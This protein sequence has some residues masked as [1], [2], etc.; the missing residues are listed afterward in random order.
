MTRT[1]KI[2]LATAGLILMAVPLMGQ[3]PPSAGPPRALPRAR[4]APPAPEKEGAAAA[5]P[6]PKS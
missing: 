2:A 5:R 6:I 1:L 3:A 4:S